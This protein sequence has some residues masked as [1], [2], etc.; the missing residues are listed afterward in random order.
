MMKY[1]TIIAFFALCFTSMIYSSECDT[2]KCR[3]EIQRDSG[4]KYLCY[5]FGISNIVKVYIA[6]GD[7]MCDVSILDGKGNCASTTC[8]K[9]PILKWG[10]NEMANEIAKS[11][12]KEDSVYNS[13][14]Y[15]LS[16]LRDS[17]QN[18]VSSS[19]LLTDYSDDVEKKISELKTFMVEQWIPI[20]KESNSIR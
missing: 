13:V 17:T 9:S 3:R 20:L 5:E 14:Y 8:Q 4:R 15:R 2:G 18:V 7:T 19:T 10:F 6:D 1:F 11:S 12:I 16:I